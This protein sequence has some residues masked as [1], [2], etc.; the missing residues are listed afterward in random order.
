MMDKQTEFLGL[1]ADLC[2]VM[3]AWYVGQVE[4]YGPSLAREKWKIKMAHALNNPPKLKYD[5]LTWAFSVDMTTCATRYVD[6]LIRYGVF[7]NE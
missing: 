6:L 7:D 3:I 4:D 5:A 1:W 2:S